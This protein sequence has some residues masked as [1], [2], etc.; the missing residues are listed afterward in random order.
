LPAALAPLWQ[1]VQVPGGSSAWLKA[2]GFH[3]VVRWQTS[4]EPAVGTCFAGLPIA[5][6]PLWQLVQRPGDTPWCLYG[7]P[8]VPI[9]AA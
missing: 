4:H 7:T 9:P 3:A 6:D 5:V 8:E 2:A 1:V